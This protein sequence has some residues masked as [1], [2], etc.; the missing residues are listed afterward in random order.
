[1]KCGNPVLV[2]ETPQGKKYRNWK[3]ANSV[4]RQTGKV[5]SG[6]GKC[7]HCRKKAASELA[8]RC[9]LDASLYT[10]NM[11]LTLTYDET[12]KDYNNVLCYKH[13]QN[14]T[15]SLRRHVD[16]HHGKKIKVFNV[17]EYG[18][19]G[20]KHWHLIVLNFSFQ[21]KIFHNQKNGNTI[22]RSEKLQEL[23]K[24]GFCAIGDVTI[25]SAMY[26]AQYTQKDVKNSN[27]GDR[28]AR[29]QHS[30]IGKEWFLKNFK[31][32]L[33]LGYI[34]FDGNKRKIPR[35]FEKISERHWAY[36]YDQS[37]YHDVIGRKK[38]YGS[39]KKEEANKELADLWE[40]YRKKKY[41]YIENLE[42]EWE[43]VVNNVI[44]SGSEPD[45]VR[46]LHNAETNLKNNNKREVF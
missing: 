25:A 11:F 16:Y 46:S 14:F 9:V 37:L 27:K 26:Q 21:D 31:Q 44:S 29:S 2:L 45:F 38:K 7:L 33:Q 1:M 10:D 18:K 15:K 19:N 36:Y 30:G 42:I 34:P 32:V 13:I 4:F 23:W 6:C 41:D 12:K 39:L 3:A 40:I 17:H 24:H 5:I 43:I 35:Y 8:M 20:K 22:Y 28:Q